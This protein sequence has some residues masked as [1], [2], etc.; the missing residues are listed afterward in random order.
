[1]RLLVTGATGLLGDCF[2]RATRAVNQITAVVRATVQQPLSGVTYVEWDLTNALE[3]N[4]PRGQFDAIVHLAQSRRHRDFPASADETLRTNLSSTGAL[5]E[6]A[7]QQQIP[8]FVLASTGGLYAP[9][10]HALSESN[11]LAAPMDLDLYFA[12]KLGAEALVGA[13]RNLLHVAVMRIF[14]MYGNGQD[15][16]QLIPRLIDSVRE[17][18]PILLGGHNG[19]RLNPIH[20]TDAAAGLQKIL[21]SPVAGVFNVAGS[22][23]V[24]LRQLCDLIGEILGREPVFKHVPANRDL[25]ADISGLERLGALPSL[26]LRKGLQQ[27]VDGLG[28]ARNQIGTSTN[29]DR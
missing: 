9:S 4:L 27:M 26:S 8:R 17:G 7:R 21:E 16:M 13:Y 11:P 22:E 10:A 6:F 20:V 29:R 15:Q 2:I 25:I 28:C 24:F 3:E 18:R 1:M 23:V 19:F 14:F 12:T 5:L